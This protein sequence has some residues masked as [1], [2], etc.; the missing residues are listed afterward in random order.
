VRHANSCILI[1]NA[2]F[3]IHV[4]ELAGF[5][6]FAAFFAFHEFRFLV[7]AHDLDTWM[8][9]RWLGVY[10]RATWRSCDPDG[11]QGCL[12]FQGQFCAG[13]LGIV[14]RLNGLSS[15]LLTIH[16][17][18]VIVTLQAGNTALVNSECFRR[19]RATRSVESTY[20]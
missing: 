12:S 19:I 7:A 17:E 1:L 6:D 18:F 14:E 10:V 2:I 20:R 11:P 9:A 13:I 5:E 8:L 4:L 15:P 3:D 16:C